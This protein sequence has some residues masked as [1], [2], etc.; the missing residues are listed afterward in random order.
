MRNIFRY[1]KNR[2]LGCY[3]LSHKPIVLTA[4]WH[5]YVNN[6]QAIAA[7]LPQDEPV[8]FVFQI[9]YYKSEEATAEIQSQI[10]KWQSKYPNFN[11]WFMNN[12]PEEDKRFCDHGLNSRFINQNAFLDE[13]RYRVIKN[14]KKYD[15]IYLARF[16]PVKR[17]ELAKDVKKLL[18][19]G[20]YKPSEVEYYEKSRNILRH[21]DYKEKVWGKQVTS[22]MNKAQVGLCLSDLEGAMFVS[23]EYLLSGLP[24]VSTPSLGGRDVYYQDDYVKM[25][26][27]DSNKVAQAVYELIK[28]KPDG[29][30]IR[31]QTLGIMNKH[32]QKFVDLI[33]EF[34]REC[35]VKIDFNDEWEKVFY[36]KLGLRT[37]VSY[38]VYEKRMLK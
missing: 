23:S 15:A 37:R 17:H 14:T 28:E 2:H 9:G 3:I 11:Y 4:Y 36:H 18:L 38:P 22:Y 29:E 25:V 26:A 20:S 31:K 8:W 19:I 13:Q 34:Y 35:N 21:A 1:I 5:D 7:S 6:R 10:E 32:R 16:T 27:P 30:Y 12:S 24:V 33:K